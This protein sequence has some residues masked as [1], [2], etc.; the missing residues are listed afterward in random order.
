[1]LRAARSLRG[2]SRRRSRRPVRLGNPSRRL[3]AGTAVVLALFLLLGGRL[4]QIQAMDGT[5]YAADAEQQRLREITLAA[6]R[7]A[8]LDRNGAELARSVQAKAVFADPK[9]VH[10]A[11]LTAA[12]LAPVIGRTAAELLPALTR[13]ARDDGTPIRFAYLARQLDPVV[14]SRVRALDLDGVF[15]LDEERRDAPGK[16]LAANVIGF[17]DSDGLGQAGI[18]ASYDAVL[19]GTDGSRQYEVGLTGAA[20]PGGYDRTQAAHPGTDVQLTLDRDLQYQAQK[21]LTARM[22]AVSGSTGAA[23]VLDVKTGDVLAL[24]STPTYDAN[25]PGKSPG[26]DRRDIATS[27]IVEPGSVHKAV[28]L[29]AGLQEDA[30]APDTVLTVPPTITKGGATYT[31]THPH[32]TVRMTL[33]GVMAQ[34]SNVGTIEVA[35]RLGADKLYDYQRKFGL[36]TKVGVGLPGEA[37]GIVQPPANW[38][39]SSHGS[40]PIGLGVAV[41]PLQM[42]SVYATIANDGLRVAPR[43]VS[44]VISA[45][46]TR[47]EPARPQPVRVIDPDNAAAL[48]LMMEAVATEQGTARR[49]AIPGYRV[50]GKTGTGMRVVDGRYAPGSVSS[51][52]GM[53]PADAPRFVCAVF[54]IAPRGEGGPVAG[55][56]FSDLMSATLRQY[57][58]PPTGSPNPV[59]KVLAD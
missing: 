10:D 20:I 18:E 16:T 7:G 31:D 53:A 3:R 13:R 1:V 19:R 58:V 43:L 56:A 57:H 8:I 44:A 15:V 32:G 5:A 42:A 47:T 49:A 33:Q 28:T 4:V 22:A 26:A 52:V 11:R 41:T 24:A 12:R 48:R 30:I 40:I 37:A 2:T 54:V 6:P 59:I 51:F 23:V 17:T 35:D 14:E 45:D 55:P 29:A 50:A 25:E 46:G 21:I 34:S 27:E 39:G 36:G 9:Y 38:S